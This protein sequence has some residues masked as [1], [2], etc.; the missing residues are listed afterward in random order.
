MKAVLTQAFGEKQRPLAF[1]S[2]K[3]DSVAAGLPTCVQACAAAAEAVKKCADIVLGHKLII[4]VPHAVTSILLQANLS[5]LTHARQ[6]SYVGIL[7]TQ[8]HIKI[9]KCGQLNPSTLLP[10][11][12]DGEQHCCIQKLEEDTKPRTDIYSS[13]QSSF[14]NVFVDGSA[15]KDIH[16]RNCVGYAVTTVDKVIEAKALSSSNSAQSAELTAVIRACTLY[17]G[18]SVN[19]YTD[20]QYV[21][22]AV[23]HFAKIWHNRGMTTSSGNTVQHANLLKKLLEV[24]TLP[25]ELALCKCAA[26]QKDDIEITRGNNFADKAAK[27]AA[28]KQIDVLTTETID[29]IP[30]EILADAQKTASLSEQKSWVKDGA[31]LKDNLM[32]CN[33]KP[34]LPKSLHRTAALVTHGKTHVSSGGMINILNKQFYTKNFE[35]SAQEFIRTCMI[36]QRHNAQGNLRPKRGHFPIPPH[37][38]HTVHMD[39]I[40]LNESQSSKYALVII[41]VFSKWPEIYPVKKADAISVAKCL[42]NHFIPTYG[43]PSLIRSDNGTHFVNEVISKVSE[44]LGF[45]I[46]HH[47]SY[48]PQSAGLVERTNGT[49]K[50]RLR[51]CMEETKKPWPECLSLVKLW[52]RITQ[53]TGGL[54]PFEIVHGRH[55]PLP[56]MSEPINK[57]IAETTMAE[58][59]TKL[60]ENKEVRLSNQLPSDFSSVSCRLNPGDWILIK[61]LQR[62]TGVLQSGKVP[63]RCYLPHPQRVR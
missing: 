57:S 25:K 49:I 33:G 24:I 37:P 52:M 28:E 44:A 23:H 9:E 40:E 56:I 2:C 34:V 54:T 14:S 58:W 31:E 39:F 26:H 38:F 61:V 21:Y 45:S 59:M 35:S 5:F 22:S 16:G 42:C 36:C 19:V 4:K 53:G 32:M 15:S 13:P 7:L 12:L 29:L 63:S 43:I 50:Q 48:H 11:S 3:L 46:K 60:F 30:L 17:K 8:S 10:T 51:K 62:K 18:Q 1:Y 55:F 41:D 20:S 6:L 27:A 47:C